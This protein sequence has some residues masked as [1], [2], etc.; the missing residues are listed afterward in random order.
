MKIDIIIVYQK[1]YK[2]GHCVDFV[3]SLTGIHLAAITPPGHEVR[4]IHQ[5][6][7]H[8]NV[9]T[10]A[11][12]IALSFFS[13]F[14]EEAYRLAYEFR[15][16]GKIVIGGGPHVSVCV[17]ES[18]KH[19]DSIVTG[20]AESVWKTVIQ[21]ASLHRLLSIY[22][23]TPTDLSRIPVPRYDLLPDNYVVKKV[24]QA[25]RGCYYSCSFC[26][27]PQINPGYR[28]RPVQD[29]LKDCAC[30][31]FP[32]WWQK[33]LVWFWDDNLTANRRYSKKL[34][35]GMI[36]L[37]KWWLTQ[38]SIDVAWDDDLLDLMKASG[39]IG[40]FIGIESF[41]MESLADAQKH[42]NKLAY[43]K[44]AV[45]KLH[46]K[47]ICV[48]AGFIAGFDHDTPET[49]IKMARQLL[50]TGI[51]VPFLSILTPFTGTRIYEQLKKEGR[52][53]PDRGW[54]FRNGY[55]VSYYPAQMTPGE[56]LRAHRNLWR[57]SF[58]LSH[59]FTRI[60]HGLFRLRFGAFCLSLAMN[61]FYCLKNIRGNIP[62][63]MGVLPDLNQEAGNVLGF[64]Q[65]GGFPYIN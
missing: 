54:K 10:D 46:E 55:N 39:C 15:I 45:S 1:R 33:K 57:K 53:I 35:K 6:V 36:P 29:V 3:P 42:Q 62:V 49:I 61:F 30:D 24:V 28:M 31:K 26:S 16:R 25:T 14:A 52:L 17:M 64:P 48:M 59:T 51:D 32:F 5:Q 8:I 63:D 12:V 65:T 56:L 43:Y 2:H 13:G 11:D 58:S 50:D 40:I 4:V 19:F 18:L 44:K 38:A 22:R 41:K 21:D 7:E 23:G 60:L 9:N 37:K 47:G 20:E 27:V 34:F